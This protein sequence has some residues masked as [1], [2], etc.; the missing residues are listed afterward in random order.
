MTGDRGVQIYYDECMNPARGVSMKR[1]LIAIPVVLFILLNA[2]GVDETAATQT[3]VLTSTFTPTPFYVGTIPVIFKELNQAMEYMEGKNK[4]SQFEHITG[5]GYQITY[6]E[7]REEDNVAAVFQVNVRCECTENDVCCS[8]VRT[9][10]V[11]LMAMDEP[12]YRENIISMVPQTVRNMEIQCFDHANQTDVITVPWAD[13]QAFL[14][15]NIDGYQ[16]A[17]KVTAIPQP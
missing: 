8:S 13:V 4:F 14:R 3:A 17:A 16:L 10:L 15:N 1:F 9:F 11:I 7:I 6:V 5:A 2:C 12:I